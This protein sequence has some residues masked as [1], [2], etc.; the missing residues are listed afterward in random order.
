MSEAAELP[1]VADMNLEELSTERVAILALARDLSVLSN[2]T[3]RRLADITSKLR[4]EGSTSRPPKKK[5]ISTPDED[6][7]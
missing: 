7:I 5:R 3:L 4:T 2:D 6:I 1:S